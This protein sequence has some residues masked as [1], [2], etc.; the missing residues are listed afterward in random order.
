MANRG[1]GSTR[2]IG[3]S[4]L[5]SLRTLTPARR[6]VISN[7]WYFER[8]ERGGFPSVAVDATLRRAPTL[9]DDATRRRTLRANWPRETLD[10]L[11]VVMSGSVESKIQRS[12]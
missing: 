6:A 10:E 9:A 7:D 8:V 12:L 1:P 4:V 3:E 2:G 5:S 11:P